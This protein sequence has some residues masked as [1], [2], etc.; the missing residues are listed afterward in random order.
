M[1]R[2]ITVKLPTHKVITALETKLAKVEEDYANQEANE[3]EYDKAYAIWQKELTDLSNKTENEAI[4]GVIAKLEVYAIRL[5]LI[6]QMMNY[7]C[8][9]DNDE[10]IGIEALKGALKLVEYFKYT[11]LKVHGILSN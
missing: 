6:L 7:A 9:T 8:N 2:G 4:N 10:A 11:A 1:N 3:A 5:S